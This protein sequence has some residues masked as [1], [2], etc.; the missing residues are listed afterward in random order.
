MRTVCNEK[1]QFKITIVYSTICF[2]GP[3][4]GIIANLILKP[5]I[6]SYETRKAS[7][8]LVFIQLI[9]SIF[10]LSIGFMKTTITVSI[11]T[12]LFLIFNS[13][14]LPLV[15]GILISCVDKDLGATGFAIA[16]ILTQVLTAGST[17][18]LYGIINDKYKHKYPW[19]AMVCV[20]SLEFLAVPFLV[21]LAILRNR[22]FDEEEKLEKEK[23]TELV[24]K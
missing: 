4:G 24:E 8:P 1:N 15:Q 6:G 5:W 18:L 16:N 13:S 14:A 23:E 12:I 17:P 10:A 21:I 11:A 9:A 2:A 7:W 22:K 19:I 3:L 20:M